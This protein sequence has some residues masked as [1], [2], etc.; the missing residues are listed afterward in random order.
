MN[1]PSAGPPLDRKTGKFLRLFWLFL[2]VG[3]TIL[4]ILM[5]SLRLYQFSK[6]STEMSKQSAEMASQFDHLQA[7]AQ[8]IATR[9]DKTE[10]EKREIAS[11][12]N[13]ILK[14]L[15]EANRKLVMARIQELDLQAKIE[16]K[17]HPQLSLLLS[18]EAS[19]LGNPNP[20]PIIY[21][22]VIDRLQQIGGNVMPGPHI[23][24][25]FLQFSPDGRW[26]VAG[27]N[28]ITWVWD[29]HSDLQNTN[30]IQLAGERSAFSPDGRWLATGKFAAGGTSYLWDLYGADRF[31][32]PKIISMDEKGFTAL[33]FDPESHW[34]AMGSRSGETYLLDLLSTDPTPSPVIL[35]REPAFG[36][37]ESVTSLAF[38]PDGRR[39]A[40]ANFNSFIYVWEIAP[41]KPITDPQILVGNLYYEVR[42]IAF[43]PTGRWL[44]SADTGTVRLWDMDAEEPGQSGLVLAKNVANAPIVNFSFD[45]RWLAS[46]GDV[47]DRLWDMQSDAPPFKQIPFNEHPQAPVYS[48][49]THT[50]IFSRDGKWLVTGGANNTIRLWDLGSNDPMSQFYD[51]KGHDDP[52]TAM[53]IS[54]NGRWLVSGSDDGSIRLWEIQARSQAANPIALHYDL[55]RFSLLSVSSNGRLLAGVSEK[56]H[57]M[58]EGHNYIMTNEGTMVEERVSSLDQS[59][60]SNEDSIVQI[61]NIPLDLLNNKL[62][63]F[64]GHTGKILSIAISPDQ[65]WLVAGGK[66]STTWLWD[67]QKTDA[68]DKPIKLSGHT[69]EVGAV[70]FS[71]DSRWLVTG[72]LDLTA[73][74]WDLNSADPSKNPI[75][76]R[77]HEAGITTLAL[78]K[79]GHW[80][81]TGSLDTFVR[82]WDLSASV[83]AGSSIVLGGHTTEIS[84]LAFSPDG[85]WLA[86]GSTDGIGRLWDLK[87]T[88]PAESPK[89]LDGLK[90][91]SGFEF[92]ADGRWLVSR[93]EVQL[94]DIQ[95]ANP[96]IS[97]MKPSQFIY[98]RAIPAFSPDGRWLALAENEGIVLIDLQKS[99]DA[100]PSVELSKDEKSRIAL[101][102]TPDSRT[103][104]VAESSAILQWRFDWKDIYSLA[105]QVAGRNLTKMEWQTFFPNDPG[106]KT[107]EMWPEGE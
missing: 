103:L 24:A 12:S 18:L 29:M 99:G 20:T 91:I 1:Y 98:N 52:I 16:E 49:H 62:V 51:L 39:L 87:A 85:R 9:L 22:S 6:Q 69:V 31:T 25:D 27:N 44:A 81:A 82:L 104:I 72:S 15:Q 53:A 102:F 68:A 38:S 71:Q 47:F 36:G 56:I 63:Q 3:L 43:S 58:V 5:L 46:N 89:T 84:A 35:P 17:E 33:L 93:P 74:L 40:S 106:H 75:I 96:G 50:P 79:D 48:L 78:S 4:L 67:L 95:T 7:T 92:S 59:N 70:A 34:I 41:E 30:P 77:G 54:P 57:P 11:E 42:S 8:V 76:L 37:V 97:T 10:E 80:L 65:H 55:Q 60:T 64:T 101:Q 61:W 86:S 21:Q 32:H 107:C 26:L 90:S 45:G 23:A 28:D 19:Q 14:D 13:R 83:P 88:N 66:D 105:C 100:R 2:L 94:W 73:R